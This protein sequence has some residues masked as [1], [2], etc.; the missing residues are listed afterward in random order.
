MLPITSLQNPIVKLIRSLADKKGRREH[1]LFVAEGYAMLERAMAEGWEPTHVVA[2]KPPQLWDSVKPTIVSQDIMAALSA[3]KNPHDV[4]AAFP[5]RYERS[6][7]SDGTWIALEGIRDPG[8]LGTIIRTAEAAGIACIALAGECCDPYSPECVRASTGSIFGVTLKP[9]TVSGLIELCKTWPGDV[10]GTHLKASHDYRRDYRSPT[11]ILMGSEAKG[12][13]NELAA[14]TKLLVRIPM[15]EKAQS[16]NVAVASAV[17]MFE[18][19][20]KHLR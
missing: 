18:V 10:V 5:Y 9:M 1:H 20:R 19:Q 17:M 13:S 7:H 15:A 8:N 14:A 16:L 12:L 4:L 2:T 3:Q 11:L 6:L